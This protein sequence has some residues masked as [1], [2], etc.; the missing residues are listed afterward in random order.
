MNIRI[1]TERLILR[2]IIPSD[3]EGMFLLDSNPNV[4]L[5]L[6]NN[7]VRSIEQSMDYIENL[8]IQYIQNAIGRYAVILKETNAFIGWAGIKFITE[9]ENDHLNFYEIGYRLREEFWGRGYGY[10]AAKAWLH[11]GFM[12]MNI[13][14]IYAS[15]HIKNVGSRR[16]LDKI[17]L[18]LVSEYSH[19][20]IPCVWYELDKKD[21]LK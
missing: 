1:E 17:G 12:K 6:G 21:Y 15:A 14:T 9:P 8:R 20:D 16:I 19:H 7:P 11:H 3:A 18:R 4:H 5:Y 2:E 10:E 13:Q